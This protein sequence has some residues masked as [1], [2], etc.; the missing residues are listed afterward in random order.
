MKRT[1]SVL[2]LLVAASF[3]LPSCEKVVGEGPILTET[4]A[5][6]NFSGVS[7]EM[8]GIVNFKIGAEYKVQVSAQQNILNVIQTHVASGVLHIDH[9]DHV[10]LKTYDKIRVDITAPSADYF[11]VSGSGDI[12]VNG[13][14]S[15][16]NLQLF[17]SGSGNI[18][19]NKAVLTDRLEAAISGSGNINILNGSVHNQEL[20]ISGSGKMDLGGMLAENA[21][22]RTSGSGD[23]KL[24]VAKKLDATISGSGSVYYRGQPVVSTRISGSGQL[25]AY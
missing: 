6:G 13:D 8:S 22:T 24:S 19:I 3:I 9:S 1:V 21:V 11:R 5:T 20:T 4:R 10:R 17:L 18:N 7:L 23:M 14:L 15:A 2:A 12:Q 16:N 25:V